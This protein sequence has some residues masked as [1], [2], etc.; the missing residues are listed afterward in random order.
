MIQ[1]SLKSA[2]LLI[3]APGAGKGTQGETVG[4]L[5][6]FFHV[7]SGDIFRALDKDSALSKKIASYSSAGNLVPD[8]TTME[9]V[10]KQLNAWAENGKYDPSKE[11]LILDG[12]PRTVNQANLIQEFVDIQNV[13]H[14]SCPD[15][16]SL[17]A[18]MKKRALDKGRSDDADESVIRNRFS[19]YEAETKPILEHFGEEITTTINAQQHPIQVL[20]AITHALTS[21]GLY[22]DL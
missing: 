6:G 5:P 18:R 13:I 21:K 15:Q 8:E 16:E 12:I 20:H 9:I 11:I 14:L 4:H 17:V 1:S 3:G 7:S 22:K 2:I 19:V 10:S